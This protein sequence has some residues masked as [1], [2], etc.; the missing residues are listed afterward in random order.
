MSIIKELGSLDCPFCRKKINA[1]TYDKHLSTTFCSTLQNAD[2]NK[3]EKYKQLKD[4]IIRRKEERKK[5]LSELK[6][7]KKM[8]EYIPPNKY[9]IVISEEDLQYLPKHL[10]EQ[11][12]KN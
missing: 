7:K 9:T 10:L 3:E 1:Y 4:E 6:E 8:G 5:N 12:K 11:I 2:E